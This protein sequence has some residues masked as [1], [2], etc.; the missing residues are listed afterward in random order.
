MWCT[1][2][3]QFRKFK[4]WIR[5]TIRDNKE[6]LGELAN[7]KFGHLFPEFTYENDTS[8]LV[9]HEVENV[10]IF[11]YSTLDFMDKKEKKASDIKLPTPAVMVDKATAEEVILT[12]DDI[13]DMIE[14]A[15][16]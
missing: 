4:K 8:F 14:A 1:D 15:K 11:N 7:K 9:N 12:A 13:R 6:D 10:P 16:Q 5:L 3:A 2:Y